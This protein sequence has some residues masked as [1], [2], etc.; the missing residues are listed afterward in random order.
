MS[1]N[2][3]YQE[4]LDYIFSFVDFSKTHAA[5]LAPENF[6]LARMWALLERL[7]NPQN[8]FPSIHIAG[9]KGKGSTAALCSSALTAAGHKTGLYTSPHLEDFSERIRIDGKPIPPEALVGLVAWWSGIVHRA[10]EL[11]AAE[12]GRE[13]ELGAGMRGR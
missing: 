7:G 3:T 10:L 6:N 11:R 4:A 5:N 9:T 2:Q 13:G 12:G 1:E 8:S